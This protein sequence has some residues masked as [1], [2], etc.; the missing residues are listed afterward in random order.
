MWF[1]CIQAFLPDFWLTNL[2]TA[3]KLLSICF[4]VLGFQGFFCLWEL[5][6]IERF[7]LEGTFKIISIPSAMGRDAMSL[8]KQSKLVINGVFIFRTVFIT[9]LNNLSVLMQSSGSAREMQML[10]QR[11]RVQRGPGCCWLSPVAPE[12]LVLGLVTKPPS[13][14]PPASPGALRHPG[15]VS[16]SSPGSA[17]KWTTPGSSQ[18]S[19]L[20]GWA[21][22]LWT[23]CHGGSSGVKPCSQRGSGS[24]AERKFSTA[25]LV[26]FPVP[27]L[28]F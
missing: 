11:S 12:G 24:A 22:L 8:D 3:Q 20:G 23:I 2:S 25:V 19:W 9:V 17:D 26:C 1:Y 28:W 15:G 6:L 10:S 13:S 21:S 7:E 16:A 27:S 18:D 4:P 14:A 5:K